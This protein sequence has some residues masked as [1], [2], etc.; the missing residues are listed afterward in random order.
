METFFSTYSHQPMN[1]RLVIIGDIHG[2]AVRLREALRRVEALDRRVVFL[3]D[4]VDRGP[5]SAGVLDA[6]IRARAVLGAKLVLLAGNHESA[7]IEYLDEGDLPGFARFGGMATIRSY[8]GQAAPDAHAQFVAAV[9]DAHMR[10]LRTELLPYY[11]TDDVLVSHT[12]FDPE[13]PFDRRRAT[14]AEIGHAEL[15]EWVQAGGRLPRPTV[16][17]GHY[18]Q[19]SMLPYD[20]RGLVCLDTG[21]GTTGGPLTMLILPE[22]EFVSV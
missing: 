6:L 19:R 8:V 12:G 2:D 9:P 15:F 16:V 5:E 17:C 4:Y 3:G 7:M 10:L 21:C 13:N 1:E 18:A 22:H 20:S 14:M 11:E